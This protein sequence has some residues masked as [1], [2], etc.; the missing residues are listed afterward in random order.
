[1]ASLSGLRIWR[2]R[3]LW[4]GLP[5]TA[6]IG[7]LAWELLYTSRV[8]LKRPQNKTNKQTKNPLEL[9]RKFLGMYDE[10]FY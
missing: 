4:C 10:D 7:P 9:R 8:A 5:A 6:P 1:M 2:C 3:D